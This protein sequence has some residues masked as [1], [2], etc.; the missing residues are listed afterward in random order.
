MLELSMDS[1]WRDRGRK[2]VSAAVVVVCYLIVFAGILYSM[3][4]G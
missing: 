3:A 4:G 2:A 1:K